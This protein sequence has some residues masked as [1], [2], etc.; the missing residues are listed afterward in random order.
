MFC[1]KTRVFS[2]QKEQKVQFSVKWLYK[3]SLTKAKSAQI[4]NIVQ[5]KSL[6][7]RPGIYN[8]ETRTVRFP[9]Q[10]KLL[11]KIDLGFIKIDLGFVNAKN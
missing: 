5:N 9:D 10:E 8:L 6:I 4:F 1:H 3:I 11:E 7:Y 2:L